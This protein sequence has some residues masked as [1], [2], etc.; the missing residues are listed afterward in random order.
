MRAATGVENRA[1]VRLGGRTML[2]YVLDALQATAILGRVFVVGDVPDGEGYAVVPPGETLADNLIDGL[3]VA[4]RDQDNRP[5]LVVTSDIPFLTHAAVEDFL[6]R[7]L[8]TGAD[9]CYPIIPLAVCRDAYPQMRRTSLKVREGVFTGGN[10][11][12]LNPRVFLERRCEIL[13]AYAARKRPL[14]LGRMLGWGLTG[15]LLLSQMVSPRFVS[16]PLLEAGVSRLLGCSAR[17]VVT[18]YAEIGTDID[19]PEDVAAARALLS[20]G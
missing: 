2:E 6:Q 10:L 3:S 1:L 14:R 17:A 12:L 18:E 16:V 13:C 15:R 9:F 5:A 4:G 20:A 11:V 8:A 19:K 7:A